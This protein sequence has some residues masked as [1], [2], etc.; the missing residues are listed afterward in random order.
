MGYM[1]PV[2]ILRD[3]TIA[4]FF[5]DVSAAH[6]GAAKPI[7]EV[8]EFA[9]QGTRDKESHVFFFLILKWP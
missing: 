6:G 9:G 8:V 3:M 1:A 2:G 7:A 4:T 5:A